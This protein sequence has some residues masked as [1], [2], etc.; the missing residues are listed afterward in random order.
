MKYKY[1]YNYPKESTVTTLAVIIGQPN[2]IESYLP[3]VTNEELE[4]RVG[5]KV[6]DKYELCSEKENILSVESENVTQ[7]MMNITENI[8][9]FYGYTLNDYHD[10]IRSIAFI[11]AFVQALTAIDN[12]Q[13]DKDLLNLI[14]NYFIRTI[15][16]LITR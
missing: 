7:E 16:S 8:M 11:R 9:L 10:T 2:A 14:E 15:D 13:L 3:I 12:F 6:C 4:I 5:V 1:Y